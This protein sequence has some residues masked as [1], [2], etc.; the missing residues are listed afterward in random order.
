[1]CRYHFFL[2]DQEDMMPEAE[3]IHC[4]LKGNR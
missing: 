2:Y 1:M 3:R 4:I